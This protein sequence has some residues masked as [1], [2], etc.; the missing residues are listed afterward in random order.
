MVHIGTS[1]YNYP[2]WRGS[3]YPEKCASNKMFGFYA[4]RFGT[5]EINYSFYRVPTAKTTAGWKAQAPERFRYALK[6]PQRITHHQRLAPESAEIL[7]VF[8]D[9]A[10][11]LESHLGPLLFQLPPHFRCD[12][13]RLDA[14]LSLLPQD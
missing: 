11:L 12:L 5:V 14:F 4:E 8:I 6:A 13:A 2:E 1:G 7:S 3:F 9:N 10:R